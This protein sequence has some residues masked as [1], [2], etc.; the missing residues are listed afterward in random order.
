MKIYTCLHSGL[1]L[2][3]REA[4]NTACEYANENLYMYGEV[5]HNPMIVAQLKEKGAKIISS[6][7]E[8]KFLPNRDTITVLIRAHGA[9]KAVIDELRSNEIRYIDATCIEVKKIHDIVFEKS[10]QGYMII[11]VVNEK[12]PEITGI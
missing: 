10:Q 1:C 6:L 7:N 2:G 9:S 4:Y 8:V 3:A 5:M 11:V 12:H